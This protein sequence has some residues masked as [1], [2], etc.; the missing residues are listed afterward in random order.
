ML[1]K[2]KY[3]NAD[4]THMELPQTTDFVQLFPSI[5]SIEDQDGNLIPVVTSTV[6]TSDPTQPSFL[7]YYSFLTTG[8]LFTSD[9]NDINRSY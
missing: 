2:V 9:T 8:N 5:T 1:K 6:N 7:R 4:E 3:G